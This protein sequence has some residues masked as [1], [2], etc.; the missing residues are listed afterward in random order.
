VLARFDERDQRLGELYAR[1][2]RDDPE[3][4]ALGK[5]L[6][7]RSGTAEALGRLTPSGAA[8]APAEPDTGA[9]QAWRELAR[10]L[11][12]TWDPRRAAIDALL[13]ANP[14]VSD[15]R[16]FSG[17]D[18]DAILEER[19]RYAQVRQTLPTAVEPGIGP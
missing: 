8:G 5:L 4:D 15:W 13:A 14:R 7:T 9:R 12:E 10:Y 19:A 1:A 3:R 11:G 2:R 16:A 17:I 18:A 6:T